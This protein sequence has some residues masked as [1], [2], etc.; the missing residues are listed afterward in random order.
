[1]PE[2]KSLIAA[3]SYIK[4]F[5]SQSDKN[6]VFLF[7][8]PTDAVKPLVQALLNKLMAQESS[9]FNT[10]YFDAETATPQG[11]AEALCATSLFSETKAVVINDPPFFIS[12]SKK[13]I[14]WNK[15]FNSIN[16]GNK[17]KAMS[18]LVRQLQ[19]SSVEPADLLEM[20]ISLLQK[21]L[22]IPEEIDVIKVKEFIEDNFSSLTS[23]M[24]ASS[25]DWSWLEEWIKKSDAQSTT[26]LFLMANK[27]DSRIGLFKTIKKHGVVFN[28][29]PSSPQAEKEQVQAIF[30]SKAKKLGLIFSKDAAQ[31]FFNRVGNDIGAVHREL[32]KLASSPEAKHGKIT[33]DLVD[34]IVAYHKTDE[35][36]ELNE[37]IGNKDGLLAI[38]IVKR[39]MDQGIHPMV[40]C[41]TISNYLLKLFLLHQ[42]LAGIGHKGKGIGTYSTFQNAIFPAIKGYWQEGCPDIIKN[43]HP[44]ALYKMAS[45]ALLFGDSQDF[46][47][48]LQLLYTFDL[49]LRSSSKVP[50]ELVIEDMIMQIIQERPLNG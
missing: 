25:G 16:S 15:L 8:G 28:L 43:S 5:S 3:N 40:I 10:F 27:V 4:K 47:A 41:Q 29:A 49:H 18:M 34:Q 24:E 39:L 9:E 13:P 44:Y 35:L 42:A 2:L 36:Y 19:A 45:K 31:L 38:S 50:G 17:Q 37:A 7:L 30:A 20:D 33:A 6:R 26:A 23:I 1:L 14:D 21:S 48:K 22:K 32:D 46:M 12:K 11:V